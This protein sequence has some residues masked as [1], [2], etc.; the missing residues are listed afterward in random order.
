M[1]IFLG[2]VFFVVMVFFGV[3]LLV[4]RD[5]KQN[6][7][8]RRKLR[9]RPIDVQWNE[10]LALMQREIAS[11]E[12]LNNANWAPGI[13]ALFKELNALARDKNI[14][15]ETL[16]HFVARANDHVRKEKLNGI[17][18]SCYGQE[19]IDILE[20]RSKRDRLQQSNSPYS[21]FRGG[22]PQG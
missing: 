18:V 11:L 13:V 21:E 1:E 20:E 17:D 3:S 8:K 16:G 4:A 19:F 7:D 14:T 2:T 12:R 5:N 6:E 15:V 10:T 9:A 22:T